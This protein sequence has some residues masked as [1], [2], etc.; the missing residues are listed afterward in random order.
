MEPICPQVGYVPALINFSVNHPFP[1]NLKY[2][3]PPP[4]VSTLNNIMNVLASVPKFYEQ[5]L[6]LMNKMNLPTPFENRILPGP[7][8]IV[9][10]KRRREDLES[11]ES[12]IESEGETF[13]SKKILE[14]WELIDN[15][16]IEATANVASIEKKLT[17]FDQEAIDKFRSQFISL[18]TINSNKMPLEEIKKIP[19]FKSYSPGEPSSTLYIKNLSKRVEQSDL[20]Y[21]FGKYYDNESEL[22]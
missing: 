7:D 19:A 9:K 3:Y 10:R 5:V 14:P 12:E 16:P 20:Y 22:E 13:K 21:L 2:K 17:E 6:H 18:D 15:V 1:P 4:T 8:W 11:G